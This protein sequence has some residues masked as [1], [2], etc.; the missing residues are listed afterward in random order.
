VWGPK[1]CAEIFDHENS[2]F[3][4]FVSIIFDQLD[5]NIEGK[6]GDVMGIPQQ[7]RYL[8]EG[9]QEDFEKYIQLNSIKQKILE[10]LKIT[11][12]YRHYVNTKFDLYVTTK[13]KVKSVDQKGRSLFKSLQNFSLDSLVP[14]QAKDLMSNSDFFSTDYIILRMTQGQSPP[15]VLATLTGYLLTDPKSSHLRSYLN[16]HEDLLPKT[17]SFD[18]NDEISQQLVRLPMITACKEGNEN[19]LKFLIELVKKK[20]KLKNVVLGSDESKKTAY[21]YAVENGNEECTKLLIEF[22]GEYGMKK[23]ISSKF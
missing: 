8:A 16:K 10:G 20:P 18:I 17:A 23:S 6:T 3:K 22:L 5:S 15:K 21:D 13:T 12:I 9:F 1:K 4:S 11:T 14:Q 7:L 19:I 2:K